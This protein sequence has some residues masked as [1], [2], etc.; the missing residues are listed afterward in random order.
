MNC[1]EEEEQLVDW[2]RVWSSC[3]FS[4]RGDM[5]EVKP[6]FAF[7]NF[8]ICFQFALQ[9]GFYALPPRWVLAKKGV[10]A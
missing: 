5:V 9:R 7:L 6:L 10:D 2:R 8:F 1:G 3:S 4:F